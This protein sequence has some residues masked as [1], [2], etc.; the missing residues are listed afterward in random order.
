MQFSVFSFSDQLIVF[1][2]YRLLMKR[3]KQN[4]ITSEKLKDVLATYQLNLAASMPK[5]AAPPTI[6]PIPNQAAE[7][8]Q[9]NGGS[10]NTSRIYPQR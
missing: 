1:G 4:P 6:V 9:D 10:Y 3:N 2:C 8:D 7:L 5:P